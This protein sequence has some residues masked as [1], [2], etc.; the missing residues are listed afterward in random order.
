MDES[1]AAKVLGRKGG[2]ATKEKHGVDHFSQIAKD[3][4]VEYRKRKSVMSS[5]DKQN[6]SK[7]NQVN[8]SE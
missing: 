4:W 7:D 6:N 3:K 5:S 8:K 1:E 2:K